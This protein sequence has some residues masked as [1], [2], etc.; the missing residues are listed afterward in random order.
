MILVNKNM[1]FKTKY[2]KIY[3]TSLEI[4]PT[5]KNYI[6]LEI[7]PSLLKNSLQDIINPLKIRT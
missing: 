2:L 4:I 6:S 3:Y 1:L 5:L 7:I